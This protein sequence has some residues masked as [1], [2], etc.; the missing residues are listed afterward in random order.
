[1]AA[2][3][4]SQE[5]NSNY[6]DRSAA[7]TSE[8]AAITWSSGSQI[9][10]V[11]TTE[12]NSVTL[13][14]PTATGLTF[15][16]LT[17]TPTNT[18]NSCKTYAWSATAASSGSGTVTSTHGNTVGAGMSV[19]V[20]DNC[21]GFGT[22]AILVSTAAAVSLTRAAANSMVV[23]IGGDWGASTDVTVTPN[24]ATAGTQDVAINLSGIYSAYVF[25][26]GDQGTAGTTSY[27]IGSWTASGSNV[28]KIA[29]EVL[30]SAA[31][32]TTPHFLAC[33]GA[34]G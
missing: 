25:H 30:G 33:L 19:F 14:T 4:L 24:P 20:F 15:A 17:G 2:P 23:F 13:G 1:M 5:V 34:G 26:W 18:A 6:T 28:S 10:A 3:V 8:T 27:G 12:D 16:A 29:I 22:P 7:S 21:T 9:L 11:G 32:G 31:T